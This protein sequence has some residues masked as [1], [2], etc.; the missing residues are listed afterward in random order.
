MIEIKKQSKP[1]S[2]LKKGDFVFVD[3]H[4][5]IVLDHFLFMQH[6]RNK[7]I[8]IELE[9]LEKTKKYQLRYFDD[10]VEAS[11]EF[12][13]LMKNFQYIKIEEIKE[14]FW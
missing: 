6:K 8:I 2:Q 11:L 14:V 12:Y 10:Q 7:E 9:N 1:I 4:K 5:L 13:Y 3:G